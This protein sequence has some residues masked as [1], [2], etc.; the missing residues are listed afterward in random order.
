MS[1]KE[2]TNDL[3]GH[4]PDPAFE[5]PILDVLRLRVRDESI[6]IT[7]KRSGDESGSRGQ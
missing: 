6:P 1:D 5:P 3:T 4:T 7:F 2:T